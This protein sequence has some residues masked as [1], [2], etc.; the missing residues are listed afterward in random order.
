MMEMFES[1]ALSTKVFLASVF[2]SFIQETASLEI[3]KLVRPENRSKLPD[4]Y[5]HLMLLKSK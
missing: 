3:M 2:F 5:N 4:I 1:L